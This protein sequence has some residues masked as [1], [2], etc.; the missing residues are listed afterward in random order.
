MAYYSNYKTVNLY[1][2]FFN[3]TEC[4]HIKQVLITQQTR[5]LG[6]SGMELHDR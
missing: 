2:I 3:C 5:Y 1:S 4:T 6:S